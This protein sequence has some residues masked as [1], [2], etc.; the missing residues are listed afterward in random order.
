MQTGNVL[1]KME[2]LAKAMGQKVFRHFDPF[3]H[4]FRQKLSILHTLEFQGSFFI[5]KKT[6]CTHLKCMGQNV[7]G[8]DLNLFIYNNKNKNSLDKNISYTI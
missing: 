7:E 3:L 6:L 8:G 1:A 5:P 4:I 2:G